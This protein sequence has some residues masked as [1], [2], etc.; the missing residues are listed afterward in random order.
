MYMKYEKH[1]ISLLMPKQFDIRDG[2]RPDL[3]VTA[4]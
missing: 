3:N 2:A 1:G 4:L